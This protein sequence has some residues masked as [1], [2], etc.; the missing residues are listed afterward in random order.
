[1]ARD[2]N[3][4]YVIP[5]SSWYPPINGVDA[6][7]D[8]FKNLIEDIASALT[9]SLSSDGQTAIQNNLNMNGYRMTNVG[10][11]QTNGDAISRAFLSKGNDVPRSTNLILPSQGSFFN[12][13]GTGTIEAISASFAGRQVWLRFGSG[14][15]LIDSDNLYLIGGKNWETNDGDM[16]LFIEL[17]PG[18][19]ACSSKNR[20]GTAAELDVG[21]KPNQIPTNSHISSQTTGMVSYFAGESAP[22]GWLVADGSAVSRDEYSDLFNYIGTK[23]G[24]GDGSTTFNLPDAESIYLRGSGSGLP[25]GTRQ[26]DQIKSH[27]H[28]GSTG[29][30][31]N[32]NHTRG[33]MNISGS[34]ATRDFYEGSDTITNYSGPFYK[35]SKTG[36]GVKNFGSN[37][38]DSARRVTQFDASRNWTGST[39]NSGNH[40]H[41]VSIGS[42]GGSETRPKTLVLLPCIKY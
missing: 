9:Q 36:S 20:M 33:S 41:S 31:G 6:S 2:G 32:H 28:S 29:A 34:F 26:D 38:W 42:T 1:M 12:V 35:G 8:D 19:W 22:D 25:V 13:T 11:P 3:G 30:A 5:Q 23:Y 15:T 17:E 10:A 21:T 14:V 39:S 4:R 18:V 37:N 27:N 7:P 24:A 40:V 16:G